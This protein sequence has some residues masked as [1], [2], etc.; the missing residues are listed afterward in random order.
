MDCL[1]A[2]D[3]FV[4]AGVEHS[5]LHPAMTC[6]VQPRSDTNN[7]ALVF[8]L[9]YGGFSMLFTG[10]LE[11]EG[12]RALLSRL[13]PVTVLKS[14]HHGSK[15]SNTGD[16]LRRSHPE[17]I[18]ISAGRDNV[19]DHPSRATRLRF[20]QLRIPFFVTSAWGSL[21]VETDGERWRLLRYSRAADRFLEIPL[22]DGV[23]C[24]TLS[25]SRLKSGRS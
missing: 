1:R 4:I 10:D 8:L 20:R 11:V 9:R 14:P 25:S 12:E 24:Q 7:V 16:L 18:L 3:G 23:L 15:S 19:F 6:T 2:G 13:K 21:R 17:A 22:K 5:V